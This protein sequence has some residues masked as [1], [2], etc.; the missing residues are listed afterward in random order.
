MA[1]ALRMLIT[2]RQLR[3]PIVSGHLGASL[4][5][6]RVICGR[7]GFEVRDPGKSAFGT[8]FSFREYPA[9]TRPG[10]LNSLLA[11]PFSLVL[12]QSFQ[13]LTRAQARANDKAASQMIGLDE[14]A[15]AL[16]SNEFVMG[17]HHLSLAVYGDS[18]AQVRDNG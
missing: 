7:R 17:S 2:C 6:D 9:K 3:I 1:E 8:I 10:M 5:T 15:D 18:V 13:F 14:A 16:A 11:A 4:Y 12:S